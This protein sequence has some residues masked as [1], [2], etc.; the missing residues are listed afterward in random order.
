MQL[1]FQDLGTAAAVIIGM[2]GS[3]NV[4]SSSMSN[5]IAHTPRPW[6]VEYLRADLKKESADE[7]L[8]KLKA[9]IDA[10]RH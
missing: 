1:A 9:S 7:L 8:V 6:F 2:D 3:T 10:L 4:L 5:I